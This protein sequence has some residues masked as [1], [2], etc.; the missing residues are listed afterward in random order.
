MAKYIC[1][2][3]ETNEISGS[4][5][6]DNGEPWDDNDPEV[7]AFLKPPP[8]SQE[9][10]LTGFEFEGVMISATG[11]DANGMLQVARA[12]DKG[13]LAP[14]MFYFENGSTLIINNDNFPTLEAE[15]SLFRT[16][17]YIPQQD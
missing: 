1:R 4:W 11:R 7:K 8:T 10:K 6:T 5:T 12:H 2:D 13:I 17:F 14:T 3:A 15:W 16:S 9:L